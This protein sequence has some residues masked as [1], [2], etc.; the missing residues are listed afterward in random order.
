MPRKSRIVISGYPHHI[1][2]RGHNRQVVFVS[3]DD[4]LYYLDNLGEWKE[5]LGCRVY[6]YCLMTN[7]IHLIVDPGIEEGSLAQLMKRVGGRQTRYVNKIER[8]TG[9]LWE[10]RYKSS[11]VSTDEY[12]LSCCRYVELNPVRAGI[13]ADPADY[14]WSSYGAKTGRHER[15]WLDF[16]PC[17]KA[18]TANE[19]DRSKAYAA[20]VKGT[21]PAGE[22]SLIRQS[23]QRGQLTGSSR[24]VDEI[25]MRIARRV[26][27]RGQGRPIKANK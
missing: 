6:A 14:R 9:C 4:Y 26:E 12:L 18:L 8:R 7:H 20:W 17:Y 13:V 5:K 11:P 25:A 27:F 2:Q 21:I 1:I 3:D 10:G 19:E 24:F 16:D 23:V 15:E 22:W